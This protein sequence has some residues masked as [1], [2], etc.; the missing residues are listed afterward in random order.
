MLLDLPHVV[1]R[2]TPDVRARIDVVAGD[3]FAAVPADADTYLLVN[4]IHDWSDADAERIL[5]RIASDAADFADTIVEWL[6]LSPAKRRQIGQAA[7]LSGLG[8]DR[9]LTPLAQLL[10]RAAA[11]RA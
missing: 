2:V 11:C 9:Q 7:D 1:A 3:A 10:E 6:A 5:R 4:V 8:W